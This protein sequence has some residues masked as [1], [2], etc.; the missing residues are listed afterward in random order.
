ML[1]IASDHFFCLCIPLLKQ[2]LCLF[3]QFG[4]FTWTCFMRAKAYPY[5]ESLFYL[6]LTSFW[7]IFIIVFMFIL[8]EKRVK[9]TCFGHISL[10]NWFF[11]ISAVS[12]DKT[13]Y[14]LVER[15]ATGMSFKM[16]KRLREVLRAWPEIWHGYPVLDCMTVPHQNFG[17]LSQRPSTGTPC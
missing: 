2:E 4:C 9:L 10:T 12:A 16:K 7:S 6:I 15:K 3:I 5:D 14:L 11:H 17:Q 8:N 1:V 13:R